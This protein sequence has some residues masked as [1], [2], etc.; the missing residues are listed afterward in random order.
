[1]AMSP[2]IALRYA[3][4]AA[5]AI[6]ANICTQWLSLVLYSG[7][8]SIVIAMIFGTGVGLVIK[9]VLDKKWIFFDTSSCIQ[10]HAKKFT[11][12]TLTG[13]GT[14][15]IFWGTELIFV[16]LFDQKYMFFLGAIIGLTIGY[17]IKYRL[18]KLYVFRN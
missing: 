17:T 9:F 8:F 2:C 11:L 18:D 13:I 3:L 10:S 7:P 1:M 15:L 4:F 6:I 12:Y 5:I 14:T 16:V